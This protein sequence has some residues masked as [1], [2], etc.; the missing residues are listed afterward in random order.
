MEC[1]DPAKRIARRAVSAG[2]KTFAHTYQL[3]VLPLAI[4]V[5]AIRFRTHA[6]TISHAIGVKTIVAVALLMATFEVATL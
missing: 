2:S 5:I 4:S 1:E 6:T 3:V